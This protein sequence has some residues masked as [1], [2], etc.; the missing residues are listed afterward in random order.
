[1]L[2]D[3]T[4]GEDAAQDIFVKVFGLLDRF[5]GQASF[6]TWLHRI[7]TNHCLDIR[8]QNKRRRAE[9]LE[10]L[11]ERDNENLSALYNGTIDSI[12]GIEAK[13]LADRLLGSFPEDV[14]T[15][16]ILREVQ[17][18][19]YKELATILNATVDAVKS[20]LKRARQ[21]LQEKMRH[22]LKSNV[23]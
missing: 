6:A 1:M 15:L 3:P 16:L 20:R 11:L 7:A 21:T 14:R 8:R 9:S 10:T 17:G 13:D 12:R 23:V 4:Q 22:L 2:G 5:K 18:L 19:S